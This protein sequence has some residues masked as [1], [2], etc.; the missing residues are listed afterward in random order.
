M[1]RKRLDD[2]TLAAFLDGTLT[3]DERTRVVQSLDADPEAYAEFLE[4]ARISAEA[5]GVATAK[6]ESGLKLVDDP[7]ESPRVEP[8]KRSGWSRSLL[9]AVPLLAAAAIAGVIFWPRENASPDTIAL[10]QGTRL[11]TVQGEGSVS[12]ALGESWD[13]PGWSVVRGGDVGSATPGTSARIGARVAQLEYAAGAS[14]SVAYRRVQSTIAEL[15]SAVEGAGPIAVRLPQL[16]LQDSEGR[17]TLARQLRDVTG[18]PTAFEVG[19]WLE[20]ARL[21]ALSGR[22]DF[23]ATDGPAIATLH[24][25]TD[26]LDRAPPAGN[27]SE[28][29]SQLHSLTQG[30]PDAETARAHIEAALAAIPR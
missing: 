20:T 18:E 21:A 13:Q 23:L 24:V 4:A 12:A 27:W 15:L 11:A 1:S 9:T 26:A 17:A 10:M 19:A 7:P 29:I 16:P 6:D 3:A 25:L 14:D 28:I 22:S 2:E 5:S 30:P 8:A